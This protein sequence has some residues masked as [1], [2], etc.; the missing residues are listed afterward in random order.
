MKNAT[1]EQ[2]NGFHSFCVDIPS[3][4]FLSFIEMLKE[5]H[6]LENNI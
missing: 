3:S 1:E 6:Y 5:K 2:G 4:V